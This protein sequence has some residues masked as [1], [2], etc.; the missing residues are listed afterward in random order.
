MRVRGAQ[1]Q[2]LAFWL[3]KFRRFRDL[4]D[5][6]QAGGHTAYDVSPD[7]RFVMIQPTNR[8]DTAEAV[9][10]VNWLQELKRLVRDNK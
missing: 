8:S 3:A 7:G 10:V 2:G 4:V 9:V 1:A 5:N 6:R